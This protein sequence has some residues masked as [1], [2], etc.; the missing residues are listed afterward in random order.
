MRPQGMKLMTNSSHCT[1][2]I[3]CKA[4]NQLLCSLSKL[5]SL[6]GDQK[7]PK[8][9]HS[10]RLLQ[11]EMTHPKVST[12]S[13]DSTIQTAQP[14]RVS[15]QEEVYQKIQT[16]KEIY[17]PEINEMY[18]QIAA[19]LQQPDSLPQQMKPNLYAKASFPIVAERR[20]TLHSLKNRSH[21][22]LIEFLVKEITLEIIVK[23]SQNGG[24]PP[25][26]PI[27]QV[28]HV[29]GRKQLQSDEL[30]SRKLGIYRDQSF[31]RCIRATVYMGSESSG[32][33]TRLCY[34]DHVKL[35]WLS[36]FTQI[37]S[38]SRNLGIFICRWNTK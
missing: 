15:W 11:L 23:V 7:V 6:K 20:R 12:T 1:Y 26:F 38:P 34:F 24:F 25:R 8:P 4:Y 29:T 19:K 2:Y 28:D 30:L 27:I 3:Y 10:T 36:D 32:F 14:N 21:S 35:S 33:Q 17:L 13:L 9:N 16:M 22:D 5:R 18:Q 37:N 31:N